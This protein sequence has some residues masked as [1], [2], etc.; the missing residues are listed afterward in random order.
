MFKALCD[1]ITSSGW[2]FTPS[3]RLL[4]SK[5]QML[6]ISIVLSLIGFS[7][8]L[9]V[10]TFLQY[11]ATIQLLEFI[12]ILLVL[13]LAYLLRIKQDYFT[14][15][16]NILVSVYT[17]A[18]LALVAY[19]SPEGLKHAWIFTYPAVLF[20]LKNLRNSMIWLFI[21]LFLLN[22]IPHIPYFPS[23]Y[24]QFHTLYISFVVM[25]LA[26]V[27]YFYRTKINEDNA[28]IFTQKEQLKEFADMLEERVAEKTAQLQELNAHLENKVD[29]KVNEILKKDAMLVTQSRNATM[30]E[31]L[32]MIAHQWRQPL[33][34][35]TLQISNNKFNVMLNNAGLEES[36][37]T[38]DTISDTLIYLSDTIDDFKD[39][40]KPGKEKNSISVAMLIERSINF[41]K[42]KLDTQNIAISFTCDKDFIISTYVN[43][44][45][46]V[47][48]NIINNASDA[49]TENNSAVKKIIVN[50]EKTPTSVIINFEDSGGGIAK[51]AMK[52]LFDPYFSTKEK[53]GTGLGL[54]MSKMIIESQLGGKVEARNINQGA[55]FS[56]HLPIS[57]NDNV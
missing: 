18:F 16:T 23:G 49:I 11:N 25:I 20:F 5:F 43:E 42:P 34:T 12:A 2:D 17:L 27:I 9:F 7:Y 32:S 45:I 1:N 28:L 30:G 35:M 48:I 38:M 6:N 56:I 51:K 26:L 21:L 15:I 54:Y 47:L 55:L 29:E 50:V 37:K 36:L 3:Q 41:S 40:F 24:T 31:M 19:S 13:P 8:G 52:N 22:L 10:N 57:E 46:Q 33:Q 39:F 4:R 44:V 53:N 14:I